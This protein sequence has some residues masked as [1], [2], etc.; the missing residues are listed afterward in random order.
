MNR[1]QINKN[2]IKL[3]GNL[4]E[5]GKRKL[6]AADRLKLYLWIVTG[7]DPPC[8]FGSKTDE[9]R[10]FMELRCAGHVIIIR[11]HHY[12]QAQKIERN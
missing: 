4:H 11:M 3:S 1:I 2:S 9:N 8:S 5:K 7:S 6:G 12:S 10:G